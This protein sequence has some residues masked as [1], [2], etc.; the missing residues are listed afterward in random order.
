MFPSAA[1][2]GRIDSLRLLTGNGVKYWER[3]EVYDLGDKC[4]QGIRMERI[5]NGRH[6]SCTSFIDDDGRYQGGYRGIDLGIFFTPSPYGQSL[7]LKRDTLFLYDSH[8]DRYGHDPY[9]P[10]FSIERLTSENLIL[11]ELDA[12]SNNL[13]LAFRRSRDQSATI[14]MTMDR[15]EWECLSSNN[16]MM[17]I[18]ENA[19]RKCSQKGWSF[20]D[21]FCSDV[22]ARINKKGK[23][24]ECHR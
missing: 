5:G 1:F 14:L 24:V 11:K 8:A 21:G 23:Y 20:P 16:E 7:V 10:K 22:A 9:T 19:Q 2:G 13:Q 15:V 4:V 18:M 6:I 3:T 12:S 17:M